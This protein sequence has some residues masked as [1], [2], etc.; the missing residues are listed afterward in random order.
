MPRRR[1]RKTS[2]RPQ[3]QRRLRA[4]GIRRGTPD[5]QKLSRAFIGLALARAE[6]EAQAQSEAA[7]QSGEG[8]SANGGKAR[9]DDVAV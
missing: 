2:W 3:E 6:A 9:G 8:H 1:K 4:R 5:V 7:Q